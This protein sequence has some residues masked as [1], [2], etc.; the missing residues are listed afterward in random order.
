MAKKKEITK[1]AQAW[2]DYAELSNF[3]L[4]DN[5]PLKINETPED[6]K[7]YKPAKELAE[8]LELNWN[9]LTQDESNRIM[10][11]MLSDY[12]MSIQESKD[13]RYVLDITVREADKKLKEKENDES[14]D[15][16]S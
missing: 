2:L 1:E 8:E 10:I 15:M 7:F 16:Q 3:L 6:S 11:N 4:R 9:E 5:A 12:F 13:K 14:A